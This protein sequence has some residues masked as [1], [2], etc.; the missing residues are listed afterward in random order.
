LAWLGREFIQ[1][2][3]QEE[4]TSRRNSRTRLIKKEETTPDCPATMPC[5]PGTIPLSTAHYPAAHG[6]ATAPVSA[7][8]IHCGPPACQPR[9]QRYIIAHS[10][11]QASSLHSS[12]ILRLLP[13]PLEKAQ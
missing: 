6:P 4:D 11:P 7:A 13:A 9:I 12:P 8:T 2:S 3:L 5:G 10:Q 1:R